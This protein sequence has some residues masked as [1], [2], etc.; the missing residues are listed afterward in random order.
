MVGPFG[1]N[2]CHHPPLQQSEGD[3]PLLTVGKALVLNSY[4]L[5]IKN[6]W[7]I[8]KINAMLANIGLT[9]VFILL[10][11]YVLIVVTI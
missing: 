4:R 11:F 6:H 2:D 7:D 8:Y 10:E 3:K 5:A 1:M 9:F